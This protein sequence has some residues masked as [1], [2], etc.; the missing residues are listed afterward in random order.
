MLRTLIP[1][2]LVLATLAELAPAQTILRT[3]PNAPAYSID[4]GADFDGDG[5]V[6][7]IVGDPNDNL[8]APGAGAIR[9]LS[10][11]HIATGVG[12]A[13]LLTRASTIANERFGESIAWLTGQVI[14]VGAPFN[15]TSSVGAGA[16]YLY[17][18]G[19]SGTTLTLLDTRYGLASNEHLGAALASLGDWDGDILPDLAVGAPYFAASNSPNA[20]VR[21][22]RL[23]IIIFPSPMYQLAGPTQSFTDGDVGSNFGSALSSAD[24]GNVSGNG[25]RRE[26]VVGA[27][28]SRSPT[29]PFN[30]GVGTVRV[31][32]VAQGASTAAQVALI[33]GNPVTPPALF[34]GQSVHA[35]ADIDS[36]GIA[37]IIIGSGRHPF[38]STWESVSA[39]S[40]AGV[41]S[42]QPL[43]RIHYYAT[44][45]AD[46]GLGLMV[47]GASDLN[48]D[49]RA[50][51]LAGAREWDHSTIDAAGAAF[52]LSGETGAPLLVYPG[53][54][55]SQLRGTVVAE[56]SPGVLMVGSRTSMTILTLFPSSPATYCTGKSN[57]ADCVPSMSWSGLPDINSPAPFTVRCLLLLNQKNGL[58]FYGQAP[59]LTP[60]QG[61]WLC[62]ASPLRRLVVQSSGGSATGVDCTGAFQYDFNAHIQSGFDPGLVV[63][64]EVFVQ[65]WSRDSASPSTTSLSNAL[66][67]LINP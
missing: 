1:A 55:P 58:C 46:S 10:G 30:P 3:I 53:N 19:P 33:A 64:E 45:Q 4:I 34:V 8:G 2:T 31:F 7:V 29:P 17:L 16:V 35:G 51:Y 60:F 50:D 32:A 28:H 18:V 38:S 52:A 54:T 44:T 14:A 43:S 42:G 27:N 36:D 25:A 49:G 6:D 48:G 9:I 24:F 56:Y 11:K 39:F 37:D 63:G 67:F 5:Y 57:S 23:S 40:G 15:S 41:A 59:N 61:G 66:R 26:L 62:V 47:R 20:W 65:T 12:T 21:V 13:V 22:Y